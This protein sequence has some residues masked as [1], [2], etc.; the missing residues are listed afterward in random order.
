MQI[1]DINNENYPDTL[2]DI[3]E[4]PKKLYVLGDVSLL[5]KK[6]V[7]VVGARKCTEYGRKQGTKFS[8]N[9]AQEGITIISGLAVRN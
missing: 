5:S 4:P 9:L 2:R 7:A 3:Q 8:Y 6:G 1:I